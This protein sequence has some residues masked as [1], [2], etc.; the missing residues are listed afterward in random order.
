MREAQW[1]VENSAKF[2]N[3]LVLGRLMKIVTAT[4][5]VLRCSAFSNGKLVVKHKPDDAKCC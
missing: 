4:H 3:G 2:K 1:Q 5:A